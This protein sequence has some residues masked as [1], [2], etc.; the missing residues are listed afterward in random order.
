MRRTS[1]RID[2]PYRDSLASLQARRASLLR[3]LQEIDV[4]LEHRRSLIL[5]GYTGDGWLGKKLRRLGWRLISR[6]SRYLPADD[7]CPT[8][9]SCCHRDG[10]LCN[11]DCAESELHSLRPIDASRL[12]PPPNG[13]G[14]RLPQPPPTRIVK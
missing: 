10:M 1:V 4:L 7:A 12:V 6:R 14:L 8:A 2:S 11:E 9:S 13:T 5:P 3:E